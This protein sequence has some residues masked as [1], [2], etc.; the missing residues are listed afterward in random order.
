MKRPL[1]SHRSSSLSRRDRRSRARHSLGAMA[2]LLTVLC[3]AGFPAPGASAQPLADGIAVVVNSEII[4]VSDLRGE[5]V[6][7]TVR[8]K[9]RYEGDELTARLV[10]KQYEVLNR[11][12]ERK[13]KLQEARSK[14][15]E[16]SDEEVET[17]WEELRQNSTAL[18]AALP[19]SKDVLREELM[20]R[21]ITDVEV[22]R[23]LIVSLEEVHAYY[24]EQQVA[25]PRKYRIRQI[26]LLP[27]PDESRESV[28]TR[29][30]VLVSQLNEGESF[31]KLAELF[32][33]GPES[34][35]GGDLGFVKKDELLAPLGEALNKLNPGEFSPLVET[36]I[37]I[38][39]L[40]LE[41]IRKGT[42][43]PFDKVKDVLGNQLYQ[44]KRQQA[45]EEWMASLK[46]KAYV[47]I[48][49]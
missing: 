8:L 14:K 13:L 33:D 41:E 49:F 12:I 21:R 42:P 6:D 32:S 5:M 1:R 3:V 11:M 38:H 26:L 36:E 15:I 34:V 35:M 17:A 27:K 47:E 43:P 22:R 4:T 48:R 45:Y 18:P 2:M 31:E 30:E 37:G 25:S 44:K 29:G 20:V 16:V 28:R 39:I 24:E 10:Q 46:N 19:Q 40:R 7:E 9:A 23:G